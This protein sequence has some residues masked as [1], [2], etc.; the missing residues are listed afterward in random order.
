MQTIILIII[1]SLILLLLIILSY[2]IAS[3]C[4]CKKPYNKISFETFDNV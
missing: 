4:L 1:G 3:R 2:Y